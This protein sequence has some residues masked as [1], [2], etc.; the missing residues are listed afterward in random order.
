MTCGC[1]AKM[2]TI[3][4][5]VSFRLT[6][7]CA[8]R[9]TTSAW[10]SLPVNRLES[11]G[12]IEIFSRAC[13]H[14]IQV[15]PCWWP[16]KSSQLLKHKRTIGFSLGP[17]VQA[18]WWV[19]FFFY[20]DGRGYSYIN[21]IKGTFFIGSI[22]NRNV[23][24]KVIR[25]EFKQIS[26]SLRVSLKGFLQAYS[27]TLISSV[28]GAKQ[29][30]RE[31]HSHTRNPG[32][33]LRW[34]NTVKPSPYTRVNSLLSPPPTPQP[35]GRPWGSKAMATPTSISRRKLQPWLGVWL[36]VLTSLGCP[37]NPSP[38]SLTVI[39][40]HLVVTMYLALFQPRGNRH[41]RRMVSWSYPGSSTR[42][43][44]GTPAQLWW[45]AGKPA[46]TPS[47]TTELKRELNL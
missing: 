45:G 26:S 43:R 35:K 24:V 16:L 34:E 2:T 15:V 42:I 22:Q 21:G 44:L 38:C 9:F 12:K 10:R 19:L 20:W 32:L 27:A 39:S 14:E 4:S 8:E 7:H 5:P 28:R 25:L 36:A 41:L 18:T 37:R 17:M 30:H 3:T 6:G 13:Q 11:R 31:V 33:G 47:G 40:Q 46:Q 23:A 1:V 29:R